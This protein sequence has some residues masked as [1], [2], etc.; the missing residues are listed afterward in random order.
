M[1]RG[2]DRVSELLACLVGTF[3]FPYLVKKSMRING[4]NTVA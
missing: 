4:K 3:I 2:R 1:G